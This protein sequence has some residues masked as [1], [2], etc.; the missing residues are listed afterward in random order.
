MPDKPTNVNRC[1]PLSRKASSNMA[2]SVIARTKVD[3]LVWIGILFLPG[4]GGASRLGC[5]SRSA[6]WRAILRVGLHCRECGRRRALHLRLTSHE[7]RLPLHKTL[8]RNFPEIL[9]AFSRGSIS[10][11]R[12]IFLGPEGA[13]HVIDNRKTAF[14][15]KTDTAIPTFVSPPPQKQPQTVASDG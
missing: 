2:A 6:G 14:F 1:D 4:G 3:Q 11:T 7:I 13:R 10:L 5:R 15:P 12:N 8:P 9:S